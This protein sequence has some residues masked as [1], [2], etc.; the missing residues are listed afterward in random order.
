MTV[1]EIK[2]QKTLG[3]STVEIAERA[4]KVQTRTIRDKRLKF[5]SK[6]ALL[7]LYHA[8]NKLSKEN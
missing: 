2:R 4:K 1:T 8:Y 7:Q 5:D 6:D 3:Y